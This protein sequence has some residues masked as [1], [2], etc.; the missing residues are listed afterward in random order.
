[1]FPNLFVILQV[2]FIYYLK[3]NILLELQKFYF[4]YV[5]NILLT[6]LLIPLKYLQ[7]PY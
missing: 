4:K 1:M 2:I 6:E 3:N 5:K 7:Q